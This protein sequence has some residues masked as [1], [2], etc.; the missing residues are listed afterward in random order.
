MRYLVTFLNFDEQREL[1]VRV[2]KGPVTHLLLQ[3]ALVNGTR[4]RSALEYVPPRVTY[5]LVFFGYSP[6]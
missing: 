2:W 4:K 6:I 5:F 3:K 1:W